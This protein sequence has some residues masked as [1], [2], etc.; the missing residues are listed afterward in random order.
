MSSVIDEEIPE[1]QDDLEIK[2]LKAK[3]AQIPPKY[4]SDNKKELESLAS[5]LVES[6]HNQNIKNAHNDSF[7]I[8]E[9]SQNY[10]SDFHNN[11][12][13]E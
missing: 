12:Q 11:N 9:A 5:S 2:S 13:E 6:F 8:K 1:D 10:G 7:N 4:P 3:L